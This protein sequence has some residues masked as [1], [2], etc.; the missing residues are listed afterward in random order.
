MRYGGFEYLSASSGTTSATEF[1]LVAEA[2][3]ATDFEMVAEALEA[4]D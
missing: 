1:Q 3:E 4:T 2:L